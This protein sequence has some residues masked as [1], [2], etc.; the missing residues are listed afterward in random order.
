VRQF[1]VYPNPSERS[2]AYA[3]YVV[4]LQSHLLD[5]MPTLV[6][7]PLLKNRPGYTQVSAPVTFKGEAYVVSTAELVA[8]NAKGLGAPVGDLLDFEDVIRR[9][10]ERLFSGF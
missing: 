8:T 7:A 4:L 6:V 3:P 9:T 10:L 2:R 1:D 5:A